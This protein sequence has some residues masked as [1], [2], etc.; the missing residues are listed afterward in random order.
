MNRTEEILKK[1]RV[2]FEEGSTLSLGVRETA[3]KKLYRAIRKKEDELLDALGRDLGK[4][5]MESFMCE[6][7]LALSEISHMLKNM[8]RY[9]ATQWRPTPLTNF[10]ADS[11]IMRK[12]YGNVLIMSPWNYPFLLTISPL[13]D[14]IAAGNTVILKPSA[15]APATSEAIEKLIGETFAEDYVACI[16]GGREENRQLLN[17][18]FDKIFFTGSKTVGKEVLRKAAEHLTPVTLELGGKSPCIVDGSADLK[19][20]ARRIVFGKFLNCGQTCVAPDY[21]LVESYVKDEFIA[22]LKKEIVRQFGKEPLKDHDYGKIINEKH[23]KR[24]TGLID[25]DKVVFGGGRDE[26]SLQIEPTVM[27]NVTKKDAVMQEEIFGPILPVLTF[28]R[29]EEVRR[30]VEENEHPLALYVFSKDRDNI[31]YLLRRCRF[32]GGCV[33][34]VVVHLA[35]PG[36]PFGGFGESGMGNYHGRYGF[37]TFSHSCG[38]LDKK[39]WIDLPMRYRPYRG[40]NEML[41][42]LFLK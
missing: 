1:Q 41:L 16:T 18:K 8:R 28:E 36:L 31:N 30:F 17:L 9:A 33:N 23:F 12:P 13:V 35:T 20:A 2:F 37:E 38:I 6:I 4:S 26:K 39:C 10:H 27:D 14:A 22:L 29:I 21:I 3:L 24:L 5:D 42:R 25:P 40:I 15:Y 11:L 19:L 7:G 32:G 34:D